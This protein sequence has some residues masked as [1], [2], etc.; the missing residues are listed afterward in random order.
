MNLKKSDFIKQIAEKNNISVKEAKI[1]LSNFAELIIENLKKGNSVDVNNLCV[2]SPKK[3]K[4]RKCFNFKT[5]EAIFTKEK[6]TCSIIKKKVLKN[7]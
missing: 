5:K 6:N 1:F 3:T 7:L 4:A 2:F